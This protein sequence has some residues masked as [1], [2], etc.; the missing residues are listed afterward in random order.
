M[1]LLIL[2]LFITN[3]SFA[4]DLKPKIPKKPFLGIASRDCTC[5]TTEIDGAIVEITMRQN[6]KVGG[7]CLEKDDVTRCSSGFARTI[8]CPKDCIASTT[9]ADS[10]TL[11]VGPVAEKKTPTPEQVKTVQ[12]VVTPTIIPTIAPTIITSALPQLQKIK[13]QRLIPTVVF[14]NL[15]KKYPQWIRTE[16]VFQFK[17]QLIVFFYKDNENFSKKLLTWSFWSMNG[18]LIY[19]SQSP[20]LDG[21]TPCLIPAG[22]FLKDVLISATNSKNFYDFSHVQTGAPKLINGD[23]NLENSWALDSEESMSEFRSKACQLS[24]LAKNRLYNP[25]LKLIDGPAN[26]REGNSVEAKIIGSCANNSH[27][28]ELGHEGSWIQV[29]CD[30]FNGW[31]SHNNIKK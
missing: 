6:Q 20:F 31:T 16:N 14:D 21:Q 26:I 30:G 28:A 3:S 7:T 2:F 18:N 8:D 24:A 17:D 5:K 13:F 11:P 19:E 23:K 15:V 25:P 1:R 29:Y 10:P 12:V 9:K 4:K 22:K 27:V